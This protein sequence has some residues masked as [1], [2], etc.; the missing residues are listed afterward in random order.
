MKSKFPDGFIIGNLIVWGDSTSSSTQVAKGYHLDLECKQSLSVAAL[1]DLRDQINILLSAIDQDLQ[2]QIQWY[3]DSDY[4]QALAKYKVDLDEKTEE[5]WTHCVRADVYERFSKGMK[6]GALRKE[7]LALF[8]TKKIN[9]KGSSRAVENILRTTE[10]EIDERIRAIAGGMSLVSFSPMSPEGHYQFFMRFLN[11]SMEGLD[12]GAEWIDPHASI[13]SNCLNSDGVC[14]RQGSEMFFK[15]DDHYHALLVLNRWPQASDQT[16]INHVTQA[17]SS[18]YMITQNVYPLSVPKEIE[19]EEREIE[20]MRKNLEARGKE[21][22]LVTINKKRDAVASLMNGRT[23]PFKVL[24]V[25]RVWDESLEGLTAKTAALKTAIHGMGGAKY[26]HVNQEAQAVNLFYE[27]I[28]GWTSGARQEWRMY[29]ENH[30]LADLMPFSSTFVGSSTPECI[31]WGTNNN[32]VG[33]EC[34]KGGTPQH[35]VLLGM[36]GA[37]KSVAMFDLLS[38]TECFYDFTAI[39][40]EG[41]SYGVYTQLMGS[42]PIIIRPDSNLTINYLDTGGLPLSDE[43]ISNASSLCLKMVGENSNE[44][45]NNKRLAVFAEYINTLYYDVFEDWKRAHPD[46]YKEVLNLAFAINEKRSK[47]DKGQSIEEL[48]LQFAQLKKSSPQEYIQSLE[49]PDYEALV[50]FE[51]DHNN[52]KLIRNLAFAFF[53]NEEYPVHSTLVEMLKHFAFDHHN[54]EETGHL[55]TLLSIWTKDHGTYGTLFDGYTNISISGKIAHFELGMIPESASAMKE[56]AGFM[57]SNWIRQ[58]IIKLPRG[59]RKRLIFEEVSRFL[60]IKGGDKIL[61]EAYAQLRKFGCWVCCVTQQYSQL[62]ESPLRSVIF[63]NSKLF[64]LMKQNDKKDLDEIAEAI[65]LP[66]RAVEEI[67]SYTLPEHQIGKEKASYMMVFSIGGAV[68]SCGTAKIKASKELVYAASSN[69]D[70][71]DERIKNLS[72]YENLVEGICYEAQKSGI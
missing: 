10:A 5:C 71:F 35:S 7:K 22:L 69:G 16:T 48:Y 61:G 37:G 56:A 66:E 44:D 40:E 21:S 6:T 24:T 55:A 47:S 57:I 52:A 28:P 8:V 14:T 30:Y 1:N 18:D 23:K 26:H 65:G 36:T 34:F 45:I 59:V 58:H 72:K 39:I 67:Q 15:M 38:Q 27:T 49:A 12:L 43:H 64:F 68:N 70:V 33:I 54:P 63:G 32:L 25:F 19:K 53:S 11:P 41:N 60:N 51:N 9:T 4:Q 17:L 50:R 62:K 3:V 2:V 20:K 46:K 29:A 13:M 31:Y 42:K